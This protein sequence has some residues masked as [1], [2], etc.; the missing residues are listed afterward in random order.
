[1][2]DLFAV[3][4]ARVDIETEGEF[5]S[6]MTVVDFD[7]PIPNAMVATKIDVPGFWAYVET[8]Y[9]RVAAAHDLPA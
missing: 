9:A 2:P 4:P 3:V 8:A 6:G 5:T 1:R 7:P